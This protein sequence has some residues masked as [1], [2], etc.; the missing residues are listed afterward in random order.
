VRALGSSQVC[1]RVLNRAP[2]HQGGGQQTEVQFATVNCWEAVCVKPAWRTRTAATRCLRCTAH[3]C[4]C[5][6]SHPVCASKQHMHYSGITVRKQQSTHQDLSVMVSRVTAMS[7]WHVPVACPGGMS[8]WHVP[9]AC[10]G[11]MS[12]WHVPVA[13]LPCSMQH[14]LRC[15]AGMCMINLYTHWLHFAKRDLVKIRSTGDF[16]PMFD[17]YVWRPPHCENAV[18]LVDVRLAG[19]QRAEHQQLCENASCRPHVHLHRARSRHSISRFT[20]HDAKLRKDRPSCTR[21]TL[22]NQAGSMVVAK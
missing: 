8:R 18:E 11:G 3:I 9:V 2:P 20:T 17:P 6:S 7:R 22:K 10:P 15:E 1:L 19:E 21:A 5:V 4:K 16:G 12:R 13:C 14:D